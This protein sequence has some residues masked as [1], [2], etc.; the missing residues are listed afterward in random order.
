MNY[1][2]IVSIVLIVV[3]TTSNILWEIGYSAL[4]K[5]ND[6][7]A[8]TNHELSIENAY[9]NTTLLI[10][11]ASYRTLQDQYAQLSDK[12]SNLSKSYSDLSNSYAQLY[13]EYN[14]TIKSFMDL[15]AQYAAL[16]DRYSQLQNNYTALSIKY[17]NL[18]ADYGNLSARF[19]QITALYNSLQEN[20]TN[21]NNSMNYLLSLYISLNESASDLINYLYSLETIPDAFS[22]TLNWDE[23][24]AIGKY[25]YNAGVSKYDIWGSIQ[26]IYNYIVNNVAYVYDIDMPF[27]IPFFMNFGNYSFLTSIFYLPLQNYVQTPLFTIEYGQGDCDDQ[28]VLAYAMIK[29]Y[30]L[31]VY[32]KDY[33]LYF[34]DIEMGDGSR[35]AAIFLPVQ[36]GEL[37]IIDSAG[38]YLTRDA[39]GHITSNMA[40]SELQRYSL[41]WGDYGGIKS[42]TL[43]S[44]NVRDGSY[45][46]VVSGSISDI[47]S[48][49]ASIS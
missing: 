42:I 47:A 10:I 36:G 18:N 2:K 40:Y 27:P 12:Y 1:L 49:L 9:L 11:N 5:T 28:A 35:H 31:N 25:V 30:M 46:E 33:L 44:I 32:G 43:Y 48:Y 39:Y 22:R 13:S 19:Q 34:A 3:I 16:N 15:Q 26:N 21:L 14:S 7:L 4:Q 20:Y 23:V 37:T 8:K 24:S 38:R 17:S 45:R 6:A 41:Y 29:Y